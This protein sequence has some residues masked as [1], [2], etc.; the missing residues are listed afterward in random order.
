MKLYTCILLIYFYD[1]VISTSPE[2]DALLARLAVTEAR[3]DMSEKTIESLKSKLSAAEQQ[4][5]KLQIQGSQRSKSEKNFPRNVSDH[6]RSILPGVAIGFTACV[7]VPDVKSLGV[8]HTIVYDRII[9]NTAGAYHNSTGIFTAPYKGLYVFSSTAMSVAGHTQ[10]LDIVKD[11][12]TVNTFLADGLG[13]QGFEAT[14]NQ[15][16]LELDQGSEIWIRTSHAGEI[17]GNCF[18]LFSGFLL[19]E[20][21]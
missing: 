18:T 11:G 6:R 7:S 20:T 4:I 15:W 10:Y 5:Q 3:Q 13:N 9:T 2:F 16:V 12:A 21:E 1:G 19:S 14:G 17:H 8:H